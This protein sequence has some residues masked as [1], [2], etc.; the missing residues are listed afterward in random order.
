MPLQDSSRSFEKSSPQKIQHSFESIV[1]S[2][3]DRWALKIPNIP[4][5]AINHD[6]DIQKL[7]RDCFNCIRYLCFKDRNLGKVI[8]DFEEFAHANGKQ[9]VYKPSQEE[10]TLPRLSV[11]KSFRAPERPQENRR[12]LLS[13]LCKLLEEEVR[14]TKASEHYTRQS[15]TEVQT[16]G[17]GF[18]KPTTKSLLTSR[19]EAK[20]NQSFQKPPSVQ[21]DRTK[22]RSSEQHKVSY[23]K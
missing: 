17:R 22:R 12:M 13:H 9:W 7:A 3:N 15:P 11:T 14:L 23:R 10:G 2:L 5:T 20:A 18:A 4:G 8:N 16:L 1:K 19:V 6:D 21:E